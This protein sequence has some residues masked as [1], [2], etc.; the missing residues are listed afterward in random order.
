MDPVPQPL[1]EP[2]APTVPTA[3]PSASRSPS[4]MVSSPLPRPP[5]A[6]EDPTAGRRTP[7]TSALIARRLGIR[8]VTSAGPRHSYRRQYA[9]LLL[10]WP[11][12]RELNQLKV[13]SAN[14][15]SKSASKILRLYSKRLL[16]N[17]GACPSGNHL[18]WAVSVRPARYLGV[19]QPA[20][21]CFVADEI[22]TL[23]CDVGGQLDG[24]T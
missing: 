15:C 18:P 21:T 7:L 20:C 19:L 11:L 16:G 5:G 6:A 22:L 2:H 3:R 10:F 9:E 4:G 12:R 8:R 1:L 23:V 24:D 13:G 14:A 17:Y